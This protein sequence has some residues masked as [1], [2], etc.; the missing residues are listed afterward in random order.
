MFGKSV[1]TIHDVNVPWEI[2]NQAQS[3]A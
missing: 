1:K 2:K 3:L